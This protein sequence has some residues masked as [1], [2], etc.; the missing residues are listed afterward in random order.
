LK[1]DI[2]YPA[3]WDCVREN[4]CHVSAGKTPAATRDVPL[5][6][7]ALRLIERM[8]GFDP[9]LVFGIKANSLDAMF[10]KYRKRAGL[11]G[12]MF[13]DAR[14]TAAAWMMRYGQ[15]HVLELCRIMGWADPKQAMVYFQ[16]SPADLVKR[17]SGRR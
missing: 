10:R 15:L 12:F 3:F 17:L 13:H 2:C 14:H 6:R 16:P 11:A 7:K 1:T 9:L 5:T 4:H 8:R